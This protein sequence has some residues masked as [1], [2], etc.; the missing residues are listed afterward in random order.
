[1]TSCHR[2][3]T[4]DPAGMHRLLIGVAAAALIAASCGVSQAAVKEIAYPAV[5][6]DLTREHKPDDAMNKMRKAFADAVAK[7]DSNA[8]F[9]LVGPTFVWLGGGGVSDQFD[10]G[11]DALHNFKV[12]FGFREPGKDADGPVQDGPFWDALGAFSG[13]ETFYDA[14]GTLICGPTGAA[15]AD[16]AAFDKSRQRIGADE[17]VEWYFT[18]MDVTA[19]ANPGGG[20]PVGKA[21]AAIAMP[22]L[23]AYPPVIEGQP[24]KRVTHL[25][26]LL[27]VGKSGWIPISAARPLVTD[28]LCYALGADGNWKIVAFDQAQ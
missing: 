14:G 7:K 25:Q 23:N 27:P 10:F 17:T 22:V 8:L 6:V 11:R 16:E 12:V 21:A 4:S 20:A 19:T 9:A 3:T 1:M 24:A 5:K 15:L 2:Q 26:V 18:M 28:R 13:D